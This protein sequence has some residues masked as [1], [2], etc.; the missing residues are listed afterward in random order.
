MKALKLWRK[1]L[2]KKWENEVYIS[3]NY[4]RST[5][6]KLTEKLKIKTSLEFQRFKKTLH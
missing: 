4:Q 5:M 1:M 3:N 2:L 6:R